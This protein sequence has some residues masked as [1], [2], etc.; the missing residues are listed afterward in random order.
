MNIK[1]KRYK[2]DFDHSYT[3]GVF[4]TL[5]LLAYQSEH[6]LGVVV[7]PKGVAN[8]GVAK[9]QE[10]CQGASIPLEIQEKVFSRLGARENDFAIGIF[11][12]YSFSLDHKSNHVVLVNP[13]SMGNLGTIM[14]TMLGFGFNNLVII[15]PAAD[16]FDPRV[17]RASMG[18]IFQMQID[19][20][21]EFEA[22]QEKYPRQHYP[23]MTHGRHLVHEAQYQSPFS[24]I[25]GNES[26]GLGDEFN[27]IGTSV[28][29][30]QTEAIDSFNLAVSVGVTLHQA[31]LAQEP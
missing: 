24:L 15:T 1:L 10:I 13:S 14:R 30:P 3:F 17:I 4:P 18:A 8:Q 26:T 6:V 21:S 31:K 19:T 27:H 22:Y 29:I 2:K 25:F 20:F 23:L 9:I 11:K 28:S 16:Q 7:N 12:K 5:E